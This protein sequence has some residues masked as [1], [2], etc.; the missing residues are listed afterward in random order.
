[1]TESKIDTLEKSQ[2]F[3]QEEFERILFRKNGKITLMKEAIESQQET[4]KQMREEMDQLQRSMETVSRGRKAEMEEIQQEIMDTKAKYVKQGRELTLSKMML[5]E[6]KLRNRDEVCN[7]NDII[8]ALKAETPSQRQVKDEQNDQRID[9]LHNKIQELKLRNHNLEDDCQDL[10]MKLCDFEMTQ[11]TSRN[12]KWR[13]AALKEKIEKLR[14]KIQELENN[15]P[16]QP[17][18]LVS[19]S[20]PLHDSPRSVAQSYGR[21]FTPPS[22]ESIK[23]QQWSE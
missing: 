18:A 20:A 21:V 13:N 10:R 14:T 6:S 5:E 16:K 19:S 15:R 4:M 12:D 17:G 23:S 7:L 9:I 8:S 22:S 2:F 3:L 1:M 11:K